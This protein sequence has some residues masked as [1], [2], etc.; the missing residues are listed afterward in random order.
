MPGWLERFLPIAALL[1][2]IAIVVTRL[3]KVE[4][5]HGPRFLR[6]RFLNWFPLGMTYAF[7]YMARYN[8]AAAKNDLGDLISNEDFGNIKA[9]GTIVYG[10]SFLVNGPLTDRIGGRATILLA[11]A[12]SA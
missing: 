12:G 7:L 5:G 10:V 2:V 1:A 11:A 3:P 8:L 9:L 6:R 4:I